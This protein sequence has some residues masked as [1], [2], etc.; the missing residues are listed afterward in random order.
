[1]TQWG[2]S[3]AITPACKDFRGRPICDH[4]WYRRWIPLPR[5]ITT[6]V[7]T[8]P[9][10]IYHGALPRNHRHTH[11]ACKTLL[12]FAESDTS[13]QHL[14]S[15]SR[16]ATFCWLHSKSPTTDLFQNWRLDGQERVSTRHHGSNWPCHRT[17]TS[18]QLMLFLSCE[19]V[20]VAQ[21]PTTLGSTFCKFPSN[22]N[23][24]CSM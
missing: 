15:L 1:M 23:L 12:N 11:L 5:R 24:M 19:D 4:L 10:M 9:V 8:Q 6:T 16:S 21:S 18:A 13:H 7:R 3:T 17:N 2:E 20:R 14:H 22:V